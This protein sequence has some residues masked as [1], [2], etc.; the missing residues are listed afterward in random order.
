MFCVQGV[1]V[2]WLS[3]CHGQCQLNVKVITRS[4]RC[5]KG[6]G[7]R[8]TVLLIVSCVCILGRKPLITNK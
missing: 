6:L 3:M 7:L 8:N 4:R 2:Y 1:F 5:C